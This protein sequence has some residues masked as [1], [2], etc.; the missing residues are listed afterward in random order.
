MSYPSAF[1]QLMWLLNGGVLIHPD[2]TQVSGKDSTHQLATMAA[3]QT[4]VNSA[5]T[6]GIS[7][8]DGGE[9]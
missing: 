6:G 1:E 7:G 9:F 5:L 8:M 2:G 3:V 4:T